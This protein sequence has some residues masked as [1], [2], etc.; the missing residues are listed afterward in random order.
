M[1][2]FS[3]CLYGKDLVSPTAE[4]NTMLKIVILVNFFFISEHDLLT[5]RICERIDVHVK[6]LPQQMT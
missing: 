3:L 4:K 1:N 6:G 2:S 5:S